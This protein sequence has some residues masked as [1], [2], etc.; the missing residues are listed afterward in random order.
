MVLAS[1][2]GFLLRRISSIIGGVEELE[3]LALNGASAPRQKLSGGYDVRW[4]E[5]MPSLERV[6]KKNCASLLNELKGEGNI[7]AQTSWAGP[8]R[9]V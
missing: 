9:P 8:V 4:S 3:A 6:L 1:S 7:G 5:K 2:P